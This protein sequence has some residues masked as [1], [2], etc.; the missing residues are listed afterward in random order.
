MHGSNHFKPMPARGLN[1]HTYRDKYTLETMIK[2]TNDETEWRQANTYNSFWQGEALSPLAWACYSSFIENNERLIVNSYADIAVP[3]G[4]ELRDARK[5]LPEERLFK[6]HGSYAAFSD[7][8]RHTLLFDKGGW[9]VDADVVCLKHRQESSASDLF[10]WEDHRR[11][12][13]GQ[14]RLRRGSSI[15]QRA[16]DELDRLDVNK[17]SWADPGPVLFTRVLSDLN[18]LDTALDRSTFYPLHWL[19]TYKLLLSHKH[20]EIDQLTESSD[21]LHCWGSRFQ[22]FGFDIWNDHPQRGSFLDKIYSKHG[23]YETYQLTTPDW[24]TIKEKALQYL[25]HERV[26]RYTCPPLSLNLEW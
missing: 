15:A 17:M 26:R 19:E 16:I 8:F 5:V 14:I 7:F 1:S 3:P 4:V 12:N 21:F 2:A 6:S 20:T 24:A 25:G 9:W 22:D 13:C 11:V 10:A 18:L 23:V